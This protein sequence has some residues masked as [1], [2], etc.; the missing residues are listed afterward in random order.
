MMINLMMLNNQDYSVVQKK[1]MIMRDCGYFI[2]F[3]KEMNS[4]KTPLSLSP[5]IKLCRQ[6]TETIVNILIRPNVSCTDF[7]HSI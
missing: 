4:H 2:I 3:E 6:M 7:Y 1:I 5:E